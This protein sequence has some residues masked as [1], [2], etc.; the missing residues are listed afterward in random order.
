MGPGRSAAAGGVTILGGTALRAAASADHVQMGTQAE[1][2]ALC[3]HC[4][5]LQ[6]AVVGNGHNKSTSACVCQGS[7]VVS[8]VSSHGTTVH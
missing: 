7:G 4:Q 1:A 5:W 2:S 6:E 3:G 8:I